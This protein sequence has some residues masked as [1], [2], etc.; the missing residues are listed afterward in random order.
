MDDKA[1]AVILFFC[2]AAFALVLK[3]SQLQLFSDRYKE[4]A[5]NTTLNKTTI[6]PA[7]GLV[8]DRNGTLLV[9]NTSIYDIDVIY[10]NVPKDLD[11][12]ELCK[13]LDID[14][15][16]FLKNINKDWSNI[17]YHK[18]IPFTFLGKVKPETFSVFQEHLYKYPGFYPIERSI[19]DYSHKNASHVLG[20]MGEVSR[21]D[22]ERD[23]DEVYA[24][25]DYIGRSG[26]E[27]TYES[28]LRGAKGI[29]YSLK[30]NLGRVVSSFDEGKLD[31]SA[32]SG[33]ELITSIDLELQAY[34]EELM[35]GKIGSI[36][37][38]EPSSGEILTMLSA[39][40]YDPNLLN[41]DKNRGVSYD[42]LS[43]D[44][45]TRPLFD[46]SVMAKYPPGSIFKTIFALVAMQKGILGPYRTV[47]CDG[48]YEV[49]S[50]GRYTQRCHHHPIPYS[51]SI[52]IQHSCNSYFYQIFREFINSYGYKT[53]QIGMDTLNSYLDE[54][55]LGRKL[56]IDYHL[57]D[58]GFL[59]DSDYYD[60]LYNKRWRSTYVLSLGIGQGELQFTTIQMANLAAI[61]ANRGHYYIPHIVKKVITREGQ[62]DSKFRERQNTRVDEEYFSYVI[63]G[64]SRV[65]TDGTA[66]L[67][68]IPHIPLAG[69]TGTSQNA[70]KDHS[71]FI[72]FAPVENPKIAIAVYVEN[73]GFGGSVA[74]PI[75]S[76]MIEKYLTDSISRG[77]VW[78]ED[79]MKKT[80]F[81]DFKP[82]QTKQDSS[83]VINTT[84]N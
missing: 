47:Y 29:K 48:V 58:P 40:S 64:M 55:G 75:A 70:G 56:G 43:R 42:S 15:A 34:G 4:Q 38:I 74:A 19:R 49:D 59:P 24:N 50:R 5:R 32:V 76:L 78:L 57:E 81:Y 2:I 69:K 23:E 77:R 21:R 45:I 9:G 17:Q 22:L 1:R 83:R 28:Q 68:H 61:L 8:Y 82:E 72:A 84:I 13:L 46:R 10:N 14:K 51:V 30:D 20:F 41:L 36:V 63:D 79:R 73:A 6:Y 60:R 62:L 37:A 7:R 52:A 66:R 39:P 65:A 16:T 33:S 12:T 44:T 35:G 71:I 25:G 53:P 18:A 31:S 27:Y 11:T 26:I 54:F 80:H 67:A 3:A